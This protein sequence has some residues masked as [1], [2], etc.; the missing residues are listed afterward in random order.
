[1]RRPV[2]EFV[3]YEL[4]LSTGETLK[5]S[6][7]DPDRILD[8]PTRNHVRS[9][10]DSLSRCTK[11]TRENMEH[12][13]LGH[14][15]PLRSALRSPPVAMILKMSERPCSERKWCLSWHPSACTSSGRNVGRGKKELMPCW[16]CDGPSAEDRELST[17]LL[18]AW[19]E[20]RTVIVISD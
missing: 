16:S 2:V 18:R 7:L 19:H 15:A 5:I 20:G 3:E 14:D 11:L 13:K 10:P 1:M 17:S 9:W 6:E 12:A 8:G 4:Q